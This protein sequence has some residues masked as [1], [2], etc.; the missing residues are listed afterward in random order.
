MKNSFVPDKKW[1][2]E[3]LQAIDDAAS[4]EELTELR[5]QLLGKKA[6]L[7]VLL[8]NLSVM[9]DEERKKF[10][11]LANTSKNEL[12]TRLKSRLGALTSAQNTYAV[13]L[14]VPAEE[15]EMSAFLHPLKVVADE[16]TAYF[17][18]Q[19]F[20][21]AVG[22]EI[23]SDWYCFEALKMPEG[24]PARDMQDT[25]YLEN[26]LIPRTHTSSVQVRHMENNKPPIKIIAPG[27]VF[28]NEDEDATHAWEFMQIEGLVVDKGISLAHLKG[29]LFDFIRFLLGPD[30]KM[31]L[32]PNY[33]PYVEPAVEVDVWSGDEETGE[34]LEML[35][36]GMVDPVVL[37]NVGIDP[38]VYS[39]FAF[40]IGVDRF[41]KI[42]HDIDDIRKLWRPDL[43]WLEQEGLC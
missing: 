10:G 41:T 16:M 21:L 34:W 26:G 15:E 1:L 13:D 23:E 4:H 22:P 24:H 3:Q 11:P 19:G 32:R 29:T 8:R 30:V 38:N 31:R 9:T 25:F 20:E 27:K 14:S 2:E 39:G 6:D 35:G 42:K 36:A 17:I 28:R 33:F 12:E 40:G 37:E 5:K 7:S 43:S 18:S